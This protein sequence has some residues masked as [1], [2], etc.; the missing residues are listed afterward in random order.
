MTEEK[1]WWKRRGLWAVMMGGG[2]AGCMAVVGLSSI[3]MRCV[4]MSR[5]A[6]AAV[7]LRRATAG[8][9]EPSGSSVS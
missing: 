5:G 2:I 1:G 4:Y 7:E 6:Y 3:S 9:I 8:A